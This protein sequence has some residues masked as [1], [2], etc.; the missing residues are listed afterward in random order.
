MLMAC[1]LRNCILIRPDRKCSEKAFINCKLLMRHLQMFR[2]I[3]YS[4]ILFVNRD[5]LELIVCKVI[6]ISYILMSK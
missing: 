4:D 5:K 6:L 2:Y 3:I 1:Y